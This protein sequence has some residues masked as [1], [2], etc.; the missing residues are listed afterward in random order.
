LGY[1]YFENVENKKA[2]YYKPT[3]SSC[4]EQQQP[5]FETTELFFMNLITIPWFDKKTLLR[6]AILNE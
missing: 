2:F 1:L 5:I 4:V 3:L 6:K